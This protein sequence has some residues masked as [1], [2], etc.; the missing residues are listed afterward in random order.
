MIGPGMIAEPLKCV[1]KPRDRRGSS[2]WR[3]IGRVVAPSDLTS[4]SRVR[5]ATGLVSKIPLTEA[6]L[7][8]ELV[9]VVVF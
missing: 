2:C 7:V 9:G 1:R 8:V 3:I 5:E 4:I 6:P